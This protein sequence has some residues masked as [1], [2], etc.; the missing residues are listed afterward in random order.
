MNNFFFCR[1]RANRSFRHPSPEVV[2]RCESSMGSCTASDP[3]CAAE[4]NTNI[5]QPPPY[6]EL[7]PNPDPTLSAS[8]SIISTSV[9]D[10]NRFSSVHNNQTTR[11]PSFSRSSTTQDNFWL[12]GY[13]SGSQYSLAPPPEGYD[14]PPVYDD[15]FGTVV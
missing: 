14:A 1:N 9:Q 2:A 8:L 15:V 11:A 12:P 7:D 13:L 6:Q 10:Y 4:L 3:S 5:T